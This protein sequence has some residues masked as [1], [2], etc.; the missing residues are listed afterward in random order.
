MEFLDVSLTKHS[1]LLLH[2]IHSPFYWWILKKAILFLGFK[3]PCKKILET[4]KI[5]SILEYHFVEQKNE[6]RK[7]DKNSSLRPETSNKNAVQEFHLSIQLLI[8]YLK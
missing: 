8:L 4:R 6:G 3:N 1:S 7:P 2:A 5:E